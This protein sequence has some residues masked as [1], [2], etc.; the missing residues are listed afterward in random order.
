MER[1]IRIAINGF[2]RI[3][4]LVARAALEQGGFEVVAINDILDPKDYA[5]GVRFHAKLFQFDS[6]HGRFQGTVE[7]TENQI[8]VNGQPIDVLSFKT[9]EE[10]PWGKYDLDFVVEST[11]VFRKREQIET[12]LR[13]G[14]KRVLLTVPPKDSVDHITVMGVNDHELRPEH[15]LISN[16]SCTTNCLAP[17]VKVLHR[18]FGLVRGF[19]TTVHAYTNDQRIL[20]QFHKEDLR[21]ARSAGVNLIPT[22]T[23]A[24]KTIGK[25]IP[26]LDGRLDGLAVRAPVQD[27][28]LVDF[29]CELERIQVQD[30]KAMIR[31]IN[32]AM[33]KAA[34]TDL[35]G[36][37]EYSEDALV[38]TDIIHNPA[39]SIFDAKSTMV[40]PNS[41]MV[42]VLSWYD[43]EWGY[44]C[45]CVDLMKKAAAL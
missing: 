12:H 5:K 19:M 40:M 1:K 42:K 30:P 27:G 33:R 3:G 20:D 22:S 43:N 37:L 39:S 10:L 16:A 28:S 9:L 6:A 21:R 29:V 34:E 7:P 25:I 17:V 32:A 18:E 11:G 15:R 35:K 13:N 38:S 41:R 36:I 4:R 31:E 23:G 26:E 8:I 24:A 2:G 45:R 14:A 44:S